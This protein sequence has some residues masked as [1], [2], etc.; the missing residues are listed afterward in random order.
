MKNKIHIMGPSGSGK[1]HLAEKLSTKLHI[2]HYDLDDIFWEIK[3]SKKRDEAI[4]N[5]ILENICLTNS[6]ITEGVYTDWTKKAIDDSEYLIWV[7]APFHTLSYR[8]IKRYDEMKKERQNTNFDELKKLLNSVRK[9]KFNNGQLEY[10]EIMKN[11]EK[12]FIKINNQKEM[13]LFL[14]DITTNY[15]HILNIN[16]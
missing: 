8:L 7:D 1:T 12:E 6:W 2:L 13:N 5:N 3:Y 15:Q 4:R 11:Y 9:Y 14:E 16:S 10:S